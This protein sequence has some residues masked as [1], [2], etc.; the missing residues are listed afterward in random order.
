MDTAAEEVPPYVDHIGDSRQYWRDIILGVNDGLVSL[1]LLVAGI[2]GGGMSTSVVLL[3]AIAA[4]IAGGISMAAG[5]YMATKSQEEVFQSEIELEREHFIHHRQHEL[6]ELN[7]MF[8][9]LGLQEPLRSQVVEAFD[10]DDEALMKVMVALE[11]GVVDEERRSPWVAAMFSGFLFLAGALTSVIPFMFY[12]LDPQ[13][14]LAY[15]AAFSG[16]GLFGV[17]A[18]KTIVTRGNPWKAGVENLGVAAGGA[19][20][21]FLAG[22]AYERAF[23]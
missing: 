3:T 2:V 6:D 11:F 9:D 22:A 12:S 21:S 5:E 23:G 1:F 8:A 17:G 14:A 18:A 10:Q 19:V 4:S 13:T 16:L 7:D 15:A 20:L